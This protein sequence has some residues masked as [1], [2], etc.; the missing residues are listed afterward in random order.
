MLLGSMMAV[1]ALP[2]LQGSFCSRALGSLLAPIPT[3]RVPPTSLTARCPFGILEQSSTK[4][5][6]RV[7]IPLSTS[8]ES[9]GFQDIWDRGQ[10]TAG[11][12]GNYWRLKVE[13]R[14][15]SNMGLSSR[16]SVARKYL[17]MALPL[18]LKGSLSRMPSVELIDH[19]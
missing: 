7:N 15:C 9:V 5:T 16:L 8:R 3:P 2:G 14:W 1:T 13:V 10:G 17:G 4:Q 12:P 6:E 18:K 11:R 19:R